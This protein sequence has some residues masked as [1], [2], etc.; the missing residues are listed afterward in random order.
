MSRTSRSCESQ[1]T[2]RCHRWCGD[3]SWDPGGVCRRRA[4]RDPSTRTEQSQ[5]SRC[6]RGRSWEPVVRPAAKQNAVAG[7]Q[8]RHR[9]GVLGGVDVW[10]ATQDTHDLLDRGSFVQ[11]VCERGFFEP[12]YFT[13]FCYGRELLRAD[14]PVDLRCHVLAPSLPPRWLLLR[15]CYFRPGFALLPLHPPCPATGRP[16]RRRR[17]LALP[18]RP[19]APVAR[20]PRLRPLGHHPELGRGRWEKKR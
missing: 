16:S 19:L 14:R 20:P 11:N 6:R 9:R 5:P 3:W 2:H 15:L 8:S 18:S 10:D 13:R 17:G 12:R 7:W 4:G 1:G